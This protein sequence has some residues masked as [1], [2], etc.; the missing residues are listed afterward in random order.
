MTLRDPNIYVRVLLKP[1]MLS[2]SDLI[3]S[4]GGDIDGGSDDEGSATANSIMH[5]SADGHLD[6]FSITLA[7]ILICNLTQIRSPSV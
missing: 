2:L 7:L 5:A 3:F 4:S 1:L 6:W